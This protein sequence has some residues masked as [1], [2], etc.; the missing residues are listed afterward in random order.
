M[1]FI[2]LFKVLSCISLVQ[3]SSGTALI[4]HC[5]LNSLRR[6]VFTNSS[7]I[8]YSLPTEVLLLLS[9]LVT[10]ITKTSLNLCCL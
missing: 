3:Q 5:V 9:L 6:T 4:E 8:Y 10:E 1:T 7:D 2:T